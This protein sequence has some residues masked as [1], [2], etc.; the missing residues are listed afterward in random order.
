MEKP[1]E[2]AWIKNMARLENGANPSVGHVDTLL[3]ETDPQLVFLRAV[4]S[5]KMEHLR[6]TNREQN[7]VAIETLSWVLDSMRR[8][9]K[10]FPVR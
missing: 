7:K 9:P 10:S 5:Q 6:R 3:T 2:T 8:I 1:A 4:V